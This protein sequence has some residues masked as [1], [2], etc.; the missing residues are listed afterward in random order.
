MKALSVYPVYAYHIAAGNK[1]VECRSWSTDYRGD[2][3]ICSTKSH[4]IYNNVNYPA[5]HALCV[6]R[7]VDCVPFTKTHHK[8]SHLAEPPVGGYAWLLDD[9]R[10][11]KPFKAK[12]QQRLFNIN[13][14]P[15]LFR[16]SFDDYVQTLEICGLISLQKS[17]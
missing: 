16:G 8:G 2:I 12:G 10:L 9:V 14:T 1:T 7:L 15:E 11:V 17:V 13:E 3:L 4:A 6:A 5:G